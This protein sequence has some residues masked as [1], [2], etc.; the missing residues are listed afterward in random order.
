MKKRST[1]ARSPADFLAWPKG[2][3]KISPEWVALALEYGRYDIV[4]RFLRQVPTDRRHRSGLHAIAEAVHAPSK[5]TAP[6]TS[7]KN[8]RPKSERVPQAQTGKYILDQISAGLQTTTAITRAME[9]FGI[10][11]RAAYY[12][13]QRARKMQHRD[14]SR[15]LQNLVQENSAMLQGHAQAAEGV[16]LQRATPSSPVQFAASG[17][18]R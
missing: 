2:R 4:A 17:A 11:K 6:K 5:L 15:G 1:K 18:S 12:A 3:E 7:K 9:K 13:L 14:W 16:D 8:S 10:K